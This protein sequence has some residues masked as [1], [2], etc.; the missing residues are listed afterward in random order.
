MIIPDSFDLDVAGT[1]VLQVGLDAAVN[2]I[3][4]RGLALNMLQHADVK[5]PLYSKRCQCSFNL[6]HFAAIRVNGSRDMPPDHIDL[7]FDGIYPVEGT[8]IVEFD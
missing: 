6:F 2:L 4:L 7:C 5:L 1:S 3:S 8:G